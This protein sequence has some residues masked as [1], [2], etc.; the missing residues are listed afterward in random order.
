MQEYK[1]GGKVSEV[2][3]QQEESPYSADDLIVGVHFLG[4]DFEYRRQ[5]IATQLLDAV[6][7]VATAEEIRCPPACAAITLL[8]LRTAQPSGSSMRHRRFCWM[9]VYRFTGMACRRSQQ[10]VASTNGGHL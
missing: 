6:K 9:H 2:L 8:R 7:Q 5:G 1:E 10:R 4:V 3:L